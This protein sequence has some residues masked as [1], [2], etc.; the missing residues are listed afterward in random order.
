MYDRFYFTDAY[1]TDTVHRR[2]LSEFVPYSVIPSDNADTA[3]GIIIA[4]ADTV[5]A[6]SPATDPDIGHPEDKKET[7]ADITGD[8]PSAETSDTETKNK[9]TES[10]LESDSENT[11][12]ETITGTAGPDKTEEISETQ[13]TTAGT[14]TVSETSTEPETLTDT[15]AET[16]PDMESMSDIPYQSVSADSPAETLL[17]TET[18]VLLQSIDSGIGSLNIGLSALFFILLFHMFANYS[19]RIIRRIFPDGRPSQ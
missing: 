3:T 7:V 8:T 5:S 17:T 10:H 14:E 2:S 4:S 11:Y 18:F 6:L 16:G 19:R 15:M 13:E 1:F 12:T 9:V